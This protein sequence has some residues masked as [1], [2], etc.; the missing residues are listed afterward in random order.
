M[1][2][3]LAQQLLFQPRVLRIACVA[4]LLFPFIGLPALPFLALGGGVIAIGTFLQRQ[5]RVRED[6]ELVKEKERQEEEEK[7]PESVV[8]LLQMDRMEL[9]LGYGLIGMVDASQG[10]D[11]LDRVT[12]IRRQIA[13]ELGV[14]VPAIRIRDNMQIGANSY[15]VK[16]AGLQ[17]G[18]GELML[19]HYLAVGPGA[20]PENH[21]NGVPTK[22]P[23][24]GLP[25]LWVPSAQRFAAENAGYTVVEPAAVLATHI[26]QIIRTHAHELLGRQEMKMLLDAVR[27]DSA[28]LVDELVPD[29]LTVSEVQK[30]L[31][32]LLQEGVPVRNLVTILETLADT[33]R[34]VKDTD[35]LAEAAREALAR[36]IWHLYVDSDGHLAALALA[37]ELEAE[38]LGLLGQAGQ[39]GVLPLEPA[40]AQLF[41]QKAGRAAEGISAKGQ[42]P[43]LL[44]PP[45]LRLP[46]RR[47]LQRALPAL[48]VMSYNEVPADAPVQVMGMVG[49]QDA[50]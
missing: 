25:A 7:R 34:K 1:G 49:L 15:A 6:A 9:E 35:A 10:G 37:P 14:V 22:D 17:V 50:S 4:L 28:S 31:Q 11:L 20:A 32:N 43:V 3:D 38:L 33:A 16:I 44:A 18:K 21:L 48:P 19:D 12:L 36:Q 8:P 29:L 13:L 24:F 45:G 40:R 5:A 42:R 27:A 23:A 41:L 26:T 47:L 30:V 2:E 46:L 39:P